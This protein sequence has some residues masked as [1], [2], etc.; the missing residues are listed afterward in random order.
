MPTQLT[1]RLAP[2]AGD[3]P[4]L[5]PLNIFRTL[6]HA[7]SLFKGFTALG[8]HLL[9][10]HGLPPREREIIILRIG[11]RAQSEYEFGQHTTIGRAA[12][13]T[14]DEV[15][16]LADAGEPAWSADDAALI[17]MADELCDADVVSDSTWR[18][19]SARWSTEQLLEMLV[20]AGYYRLVSGL[21]NSVGVAL[22][23]QTPRWPEGAV[24]R[25]RA[26][27]MA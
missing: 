7:P 19:L 1:Q 11:W 15:R 10:R 24:A 12:G 22:E 16:W 17:A 3:V 27:E 20:L 9:G 21:L 26:P 5:P 2:A 4:N 23:P 8:S 25:L 18:R 14:D 13:L 6:A